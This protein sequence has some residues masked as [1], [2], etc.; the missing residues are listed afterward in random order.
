MIKNAV[1]TSFRKYMEILKPSNIAWG[2]AEWCGILENSL[3]VHQN[4]NHRV[5]IL[6]RNSTLKPTRN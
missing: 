1:I 4:V 5:I 6:P 3:A 2:S